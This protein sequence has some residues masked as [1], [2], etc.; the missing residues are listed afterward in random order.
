[1]E[2][3][4]KAMKIK[5]SST[6][7]ISAKAAQLKAEGVDIVTFGVGEPDFD[8]PKHIKDAAIMAI[9]QGFTRY[10]PAAG[11]MELRQAVCDKLKR[12]NELSYTAE[13]VII[14]NGAKH[15]LT[16]AFMT[17]LNDGDEVIIPA[18]Y[19]L[20]YSEMVKLAGG[21]PVIVTTKKENHF[22]LS[23]EELQ[24]AYTEKTKAIVLTSPS[25][26]TGMVSVLEDLQRIA[27]FAI[28]KDI[29]VISDEI[30][31]KLIYDEGKKHI[32]IASLGKEIYDRT[33]VINGVSKSYAMTGWRIGFTAA[34]IEI[35]KVISSMQSHTASNPNSI[36]QKATVV[37]LNGDQSC[38]EE[39]CKEF[40][41][42]RDYIF[43][44]EEKIPLIS[45]LKPEGAFYL[46]VDVSKTFGKKYE[47][48]LI[49]SA[50]DFAKVLVEKKYVAVVP[51]ADF[52]MADYIRLSYATSME[53]IKKGMDRIE[54]LVLGLE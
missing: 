49:K 53:L 28:E 34:P 9:E 35:A 25:N 50:I 11:T 43:E 4:K 12:D 31:E 8:T 44:R 18:P 46:F 37:A 7:E 17:I 26:P 3:S 13:Q 15:S 20:S 6:L 30:Y 1:M 33:I 10:T 29:I 14:S 45:A 39:M 16:N 36:A 23:E 27:D 41:K 22:M 38:I 5:P 32:S 24:G 54:E 2:L 19:W 51:C 48:S 40:K 52:G 42:R 21:V 47:G